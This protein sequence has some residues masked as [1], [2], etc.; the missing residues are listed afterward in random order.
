MSGLKQQASA[1]SPSV[2]TPLAHHLRRQEAVLNAVIGAAATNTAVPK[3][4]DDYIPPPP[5]SPPVSPRGTSPRGQKRS[6]PLVRT[7]PYKRNAGYAARND[8]SR[9]WPSYMG[10]HDRLAQ[11]PT[12]ARRTSPVRAPSGSV[13]P[14]PYDRSSRQLSAG[15][16]TPRG[17]GPKRSAAPAIGQGSSSSRTDERGRPVFQVSTKSNFDPS[18]GDFG[19]P[20]DLPPVRPPIEAAT[21]G[22]REGLHTV[23]ARM[24]N[25]SSRLAELTQLQWS[26]QVEADQLRQQISSAEEERNAVRVQLET[27]TSKMN[28]TMT[29]LGR[30]I[31]DKVRQVE[32]ARAENAR[33]RTALQL[34]DSR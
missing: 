4:Q 18:R 2:S 24:T 34:A 29:L 23:T 20:A 16:G 21:N 5:Y 31:E 11:S 13:Q 8:A 32:A 9:G 7:S 1:N 14:K 26:L 27:I 19:N 6:S 17:N 3:L 30:E 12:G 10:V 28:D 33:L 22:V 15:S 25:L